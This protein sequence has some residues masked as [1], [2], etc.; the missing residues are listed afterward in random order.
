MFRTYA[1]VYTITLKYKE[2]RLFFAPNLA[3]GDY[4][5]PYDF[6]KHQSNPWPSH[7]YWV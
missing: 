1:D 5:F 7:F 4:L 6:F 2:N 3:D